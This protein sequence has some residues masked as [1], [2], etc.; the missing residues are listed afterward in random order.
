MR[1]V[2]PGDLF[3]LRRYP[4]RRPW[5]RRVLLREP[6]PAEFG[7]VGLN[8]RPLAGAGEST[9]FLSRTKIRPKDHIN[10][11]REIPTVAIFPTTPK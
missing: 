11:L 2:T 4:D 5:D 3:F 10:L 1:E 9:L 6:Q 8:W 7:P